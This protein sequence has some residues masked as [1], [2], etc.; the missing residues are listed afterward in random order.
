[1]RQTLRSPTNNVALAWAGGAADKRWGVKS[2]A[3]NYPLGI[4]RCKSGWI[5]VTVVTPVQWKNILPLL[6]VAD[7]PAIGLRGQP[8]S[9][10]N[11]DVIEA[12]FAAA[13]PATYRRGM[14]RAGFAASPALCRGADHGG[15]ALQSGTSPCGSFVPVRHG[16][17]AYEVPRSPLRLTVTPPKAGGV[18]PHSRGHPALG[19]RTAPR[20]NACTGD[21]QAASA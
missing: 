5:G 16:A 21:A 15:S 13:I 12:R 2:F 18:V 10:C 3:P 9:P 19:R 4:Y 20:T 14:V 1:M 6:D 17:R 8:G 11:A 7:S